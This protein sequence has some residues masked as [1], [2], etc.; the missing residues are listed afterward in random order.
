VIRADGQP[1]GGGAV[2]IRNLIRIVDY[3]PTTYAVGIV[4]IAVSPRSQRLGDMAAGTIV[5][6][7]RPVRVPVS[8]PMAGLAHAGL[9]VAPGTGLDATALTERE[10]GIVR[11]FLERRTSLHAGARTALAGQIASPLRRRV[12][13]ARPDMSDEV[14]LE[15]LARAYRERFA[16]SSM[17]TEPRRDAGA[18]SRPDRPD[19]PDLPS[20]A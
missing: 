17:P 6:R 13:G 12:P 16:S 3:L 11:T 10:Y 20:P 8:L 14:F 7:D 9:A 5:V 1:V 18:V 19:R 15:V 4:S 2:L